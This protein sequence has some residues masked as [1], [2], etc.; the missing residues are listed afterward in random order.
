[1]YEHIVKQ[2]EQMADE[3]VALL[4]RLIRFESITGNEGPIQKEV[5]RTLEEIGLNIDLWEPNAEELKRHPI[6]SQVESNFENRPVVVGIWAGNG[7]GRSLLLNGHVDVVKPGPGW[8][9]DPFGGE[10]INNKVYGRG[11]SDMKGGVAAM[12]MALK[13]L[14]SLN[15][16][17]KGRILLETVVDEENG[18]NGSL[19]GL[20]RGHTADACIN[21][22]ASDLDIQRAHSG[23]MEFFLHVY[24]QPTPIS[25]KDNAVSPIDKG[26]RLVQAMMDLESILRVTHN[27]PLFPGGSMNI[28]VTS[29]HSGIQTT[30]LPDEAVIG[31][32]VRMLPGMK[33]EETRRLVEQYVARVAARDP[34]MR[35]R[36][37]KFRWKGLYA[38]SMEVSEDNPLVV[39]L[40]ESFSRVTGRASRTSGHEGACDPWIINNYGNIPTVIFGPGKITQM[41][42]VDEYVGIKDVITA[43]KTLALAIYKWSFKNG[44]TLD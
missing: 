9:K 13:V 8:S 24:G 28:Y 23:I 15:L 4:V 29:F 10:I 25:R 17:P 11:A 44:G 5:A 34:F 20:L 6:C 2:V 26:Y 30:V 3:V 18:I 40:K 16:R 14:K 36:P 31:G 43:T 7:S 19:A 12:I 21:C 27:H 38:E 22:E 39:C 1:M 37:P 41:H 33:A 32:M 42:A 35:Q